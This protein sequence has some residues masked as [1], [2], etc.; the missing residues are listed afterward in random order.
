M[1]NRRT[2]KQKFVNPYTPKNMPPHIER[3]VFQKLCETHIPECA[4]RRIDAGKG[5]YVGAEDYVRVACRCDVIMEYRKTMKNMENEEFSA[6][7]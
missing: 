2:K 1:D 4:Q 5:Y 7:R 6:N 3:L